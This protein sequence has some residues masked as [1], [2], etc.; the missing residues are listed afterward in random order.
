MKATHIVLDI[1]PKGLTYESNKNGKAVAKVAV[2]EVTIGSYTYKAYTSI[3]RVNAAEAEK[4]KPQPVTVTKADDRIN[5]LESK[6][7]TLANAMQQLVA[8]QM[9]AVAPEPK[10]KAQRT[11]Q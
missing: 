9:A 8:M 5:Q 1:D 10:A 4:A 3:Y 6:L 11:R 2:Q 7:D